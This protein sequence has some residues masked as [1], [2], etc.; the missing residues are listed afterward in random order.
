MYNFAIEKRETK[1]QDNMKR[2][3]LTTVWLV[4]LTAA[5]AQGPNGSGTYYK[6]ADGLSGASL[7]TALHKIISNGSI[8]IGYAGLIEAYKTTDM[9]ADG[10]L[11]DWYSNATNYT[12]DD[13]HGNNAE[14]AGWNREHSVPQSWFSKANPMKADIVHVVPTDAYVNNRRG[15]YPFGE[16]GS[17]T[18]SSKNNYC[19]LG[20]SKTPGYSGKVFEPNDELKGDIARIYFY[21]ITRYQDKCGNWS[22]GVFTSTYP[23]LVRWTLD[24]MMRWSKKDPVD[25]R[26]RER[27]KAVYSL[28]FNR[29]P[30][31][32]YPGLEEYAWGDKMDEP[33]SYDNYGG[34]SVTVAVRQPVFSPYGGMFEESVTVA[35]SSVTEGAAIY[36]TTDGTDAT[37]T[38][39]QLYSGA[40]TL[41]QSAT[42]KA[43]AVKD[44]SS[45]LQASA[46]FTIVGAGEL[47]VDPAPVAG[48]LF[49]ESFDDCDDT[50]GNDGQ[51]SGQN[52]D[53]TL[54]ADNPGW[55][56]DGG[57]AA[58]ECARFGSSSKSG[59]VTSPEIVLPG[60]TAKLTF[61][62]GAWNSSGDGTSLTVR[63][64]GDGVTISPSTFT[65]KKGAWTDFEATLS[66]T[67]TIQI[68]FTPVKRFFLDE[69]KVLTDA[70]GIA[71][72]QK[73]AVSGGCYYTL[74]GRTIQGV[75]TQKGVYIVN[76]RKYV[77]K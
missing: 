7:K 19:R 41:T 54:S 68:E 76:G 69:V 63:V 72:L 73:P 32:D 20:S 37:A 61:K 28:Q 1:N 31:V 71:G 50:G 11:R 16:V 40:I 45:S 3:L 24:M 22:G 44:G 62:A 59:V 8:N 53:G 52:A 12:W 36:Y 6:N 42:L 49:Y 23:G 4:A 47:P 60:A 15:S 56:F 14:G 58:N 26:E 64:V 29:N 34:G 67:G 66:G 9:R 57:Y 35:I 21:M 27:N 17:A 74:D 70:T 5:W 39:G 13:N 10:K 43:I 33:F 18:W 48:E 30:F 2:I 51:W 65:M 38:G 55:V 46:D 25:E 77:V 75:P